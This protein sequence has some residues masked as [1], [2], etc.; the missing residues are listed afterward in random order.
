METGSLAPGAPDPL[1]R[2]LEHEGGAPVYA[3]IH[4]KSP[5]VNNKDPRAADQVCCDVWSSAHLCS[6]CGSQTLKQLPTPTHSPLSYAFLLD[7]S[8]SLLLVITPRSRGTRGRK[9]SSAER[10]GITRKEECLVSAQSSS[11][12]NQMY[13]DHRLIYFP[14]S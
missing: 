3:M 4:S 9:Y 10:T 13:P 1:P 6:G 11:S 5:K 14:S 12:A 2:V 8:L 7:L